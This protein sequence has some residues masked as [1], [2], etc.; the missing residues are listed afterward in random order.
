MAWPG[1]VPLLALPAASMMARA[2]LQPWAFMW[3][4]AVSIFLGCKWQTWWSALGRSTHVGI[5]LSLGYLFCWP[6]MDAEPFL[7]S[8]GSPQHPGFGEWIWASAKTATGAVLLWC[9]DRRVP[10]GNYLLAGW[11]GML[12]MIMIL[13]FGIFHLLSLALRFVGVNTPP[14][15][16][17]PLAANSLS[18]FWGRRWNLGFRQL[19]H[20]LVFQPVRRKKGWI[21][22]ILLSFFF[23]GIIH[24]LVISLPA[25]GDYG[26]PTGYFVL[27]GLGVLLERSALGKTLGLG[28]GVSGWLFAA[29]CAGVPAFLLFHPLFVE[30][31]ILPFLHAIKAR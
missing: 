13:H 18:D 6:G 27:Q 14:V 24:D 20:Q 31:V 17:A 16:Q 30:R 26:L 29:I 11:V 3:L 15:M 4:L 12:G 5:G 7:G 19:T 9:I 1:W 21:V 2:R 22:A 28:S 23:S 10:E 25:G 8:K